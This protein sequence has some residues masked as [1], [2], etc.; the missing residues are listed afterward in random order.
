MEVLGESNN[1]FHLQGKFSLFCLT[2]TFINDNLYIEK[3]K[4]RLK[5][6]IY[7]SGYETL[8]EFA[9]EVKLSRKTIYM[10]AEGKAGE[11]KID[12]MLEIV[13]KLNDRLK[14]EQS[15]LKF[16]LKINDVFPQAAEKV[17]AIFEE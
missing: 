12:K 7:L 5:G 9:R 8:E 4:A 11:I 14:K 2:L 17:K 6:L 1:H 16:P 15:I 13:K 10:L 3:M